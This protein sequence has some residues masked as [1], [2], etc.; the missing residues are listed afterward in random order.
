MTKQ[1][2]L[3]NCSSYYNKY[4][5][6]QDETD[7]QKKLHAI[8]SEDLDEIQNHLNAD[9]DDCYDQITPNA[10]DTESNFASVGIQDLH[11]D[12]NEGYDMS[13]DIG[14]PSAA[15]SNNE[16]QL[17]L[18]ELQDTEYR[19]LVQKLNTEQKHIFYHILHHRKNKRYPHLPFPQ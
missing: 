19:Q 16:Q 8:C 3:E 15:V 13:E 4:L 6:V 5:I 2:S 11:P 7:Q 1:T 9:N 17:I 14:I 10:Q 12:L 18:H